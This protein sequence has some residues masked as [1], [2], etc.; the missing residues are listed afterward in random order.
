MSYNEEIYCGA[1]IKGDLR[2]AMEYISKFP[3]KI[4]LY[5]RYCE[6]FE[7][8]EYIKYDLDPRLD[9]LL[10]AYQQYYREIF[11]L[12]GD[13]QLAAGK[14]RDRLLSGFGITDAN[15][16][17]CDL[18]EK[19]LLPLFA[20]HGYQF[21]GGK[22]SGYYG[23][24]VW[25]TTERVTYAVELP[26]GVESYTVKMLDRFVSLGWMDY[27]SFGMVGTGGWT[28]AD[29]CINCVRSAW[30]LNG[31]A[32]R[33]SLL[34][35][36]AQHARD[37]RVNRNLSSEDLEYRAKLVELIYTEERNL[38]RTFVEEADPAAADN[39][40]ARAANRIVQEMVRALGVERLEIGYV[41][42]WRI[43]AVARELFEKSRN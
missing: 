10:L 38:L 27:L 36:E 42:V 40:H 30:D 37:L 39:G 16:Q 7:L 5:A 2:G 20:E 21:L 14:L 6:L 1:I 33:V 17:L 41:P 31:E 22:T 23:P 18:E 24:Y 15:V 3:E 28:D 4:Q 43:Q 13:K 8:E 9:E 35:H 29:G 26:D 25:R 19:Y 34:K 11:Y 12:C 32:F